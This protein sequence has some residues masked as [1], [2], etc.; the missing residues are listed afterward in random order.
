MIRRE[1]LK[2]TASALVC[3]VTVATLGLTS[4][5]SRQARADDQ[6]WLLYVGTYSRP[7]DGNR[8]ASEGIYGTHFDASTGKFGEVFLAA[9]AGDPSFVAIHPSG[10]YLYSIGESGKFEGKNQ[11]V[12]QAYAI[13]Q[14]TGRLTLLNEQTTGGAGPCHLVVDAL[15]QTALIANYGGGSAASVRIQPDGKLGELAS[16]HQHQGSSVNP[17]RQQEPHAHSINLDADNKFAYVADLGLDRILVYAFDAASGKL[18][19]NPKQVEVEP[20]AGPRHFAFHPQGKWAF[21]INELASSITSFRCDPQTGTLATVENVSTLPDKY[22]QP[23]YTAEVVVHPTGKFVYG[24]NRG[25]DSIA[26]FKFD[27]KNGSLDRVEIEPIGGRT[28]RNFVIDPSG[29]YLLAEGQ[30]TDSVTVF[31]IDAT[32]GALKPT[33]EKLTV[34]VPV[35]I[36]FVRGH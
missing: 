1:I 34:P 32:T 8:P 31:E 11:G 13:D 27:D 16:F 20:G 28:P 33:G 30:D 9:K 5:G 26:V 21:V 36:R 7:A 17:Q 25:H 3:L 35:C 18:L 29:K 22:E 4:V 23:S 10:K 2:K 19:P 14:A 12:I 15:G 24:S 6:R